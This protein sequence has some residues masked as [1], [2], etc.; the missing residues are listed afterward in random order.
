MESHPIVV[1]GL[2]HC[3]NFCRL[4]RVL[5]AVFGLH[6]IL[7]AATAVANPIVLTNS[8]QIRA[9]SQ[10]EAARSVPVNLTGVVVSSDW[11]ALDLVDDTSGIYTE[12]N[13]FLSL[14]LRPNISAAP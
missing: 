4:G 13:A 1:T 14:D 3:Q 2:S 5:A 10:A 9:L 12:G 7:V 6:Q 8:A 11:V